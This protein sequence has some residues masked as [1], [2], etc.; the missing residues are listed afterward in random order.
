VGAK[1]GVSYSY[2]RENRLKVFEKRVLRGIFKPKR[3]KVTKG[4][5]KFHNDKLHNFYSSPNNIGMIKLIIMR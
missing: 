3:E 2:L 4:R 1:L 5:R